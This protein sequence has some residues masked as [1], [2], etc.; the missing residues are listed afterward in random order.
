MLSNIILQLDTH[1][2]PFVET[3]MNCMSTLWSSSRQPLIQATILHTLA[4]LV[5]ALDS[6][7]VVTLYPHLQAALTL[8]V[9]TQSPAFV[10]LHDE[11]MYLWFSLVQQFPRGSNDS[12]TRSLV[13]LFTKLPALVDSCVKQQ[14]QILA[15]LSL[16]RDLDISSQN[17]KQMLQMSDCH[18]IQQAMHIVHAY[19]LWGGS[20]FVE[21]HLSVLTQLFEMAIEYSTRGPKLE[22]ALAALSTFL[23]MFP[24]QAP[25]TLQHVLKRLVLSLFRYFK[26]KEVSCSILTLLCRV[27]LHTRDVFFNLFQELSSQTS[28]S[29]YGLTSSGGGNNSSGFGLSPSS[30]SSSSSSSSLTQYLQFWLLKVICSDFRFTLTSF[31]HR[32]PFFKDSV[33][34]S[35]VH[36]HHIYFHSLIHSHLFAIR[37]PLHSPLH[38]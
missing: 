34:I 27:L 15:T 13:E 28:S 26:D 11:G 21:Q 1:V 6:A 9:D 2:R 16:N 29:E 4:S 37:S 7:D 30:S 5:Q 23:Q 8:S 14:Q 24:T 33:F 18:Q 25:H 35:F 19:L 10:S 32:I 36:E 31:A 17:V 20:T 3:I 12:A 38:S 22:P